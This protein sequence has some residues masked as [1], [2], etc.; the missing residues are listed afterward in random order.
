MG[1][2]HCGHLLTCSPAQKGQRNGV[3]VRESRRLPEIHRLHGPDHK[4]DAEIH[5]RRENSPSAV[6]SKDP[7]TDRQHWILGQLRDNVKLT[8]EM[9]EG[10]FRIKDKQAKRALSGL[11]RRGLIRFI[12]KPRPGY[13]VLCR[14]TQNARA[15]SLGPFV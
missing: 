14:N 6:E 8:R 11:S 4:P 2:F 15:M 9:V 13:Y 5:H 10:K 3:H 7:L 12:R 1:P